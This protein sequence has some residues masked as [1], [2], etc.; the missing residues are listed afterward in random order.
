MWFF[1]GTSQEGP[2]TVPMLGSPG[3]LLTRLFTGGNGL[4]IVQHSDVITPE[5]TSL[6]AAYAQDAG[7]WEASES[8]E[9]MIIDGPDTVRI[10]RT[11]GLLPPI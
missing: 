9:Y 6:I 11:H 8:L 4:H 3:E 5:V 2:L 10:F 7:A 1:P